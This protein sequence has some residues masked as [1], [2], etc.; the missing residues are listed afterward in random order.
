MS[1]EVEILVVAFQ[2]LACDA[3]VVASAVAS[4]VALSFALDFAS[5]AELAVVAGLL[6][7]LQLFGCNAA[8]GG[9]LA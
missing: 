5:V 8:G 6:V 9:F 7:V 3:V 1:V 2:L 4:V